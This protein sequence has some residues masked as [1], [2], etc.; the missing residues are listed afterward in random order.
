MVFKCMQWKP[1]D[2]AD[3]WKQSRKELPVWSSAYNCVFQQ[4][5]VHFPCLKIPSMTN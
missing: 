2:D 5:N 4:Q 3:K 1:S